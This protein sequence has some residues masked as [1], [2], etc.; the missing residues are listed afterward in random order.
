[1]KRARSFFFVCLG[2]LAL[3]TCGCAKKT[4]APPT[5][6]LPPEARPVDHIN[7]SYSGGSGGAM[8]VVATQD[9][10]VIL[11]PASSGAR[12]VFDTRVPL[13]LTLTCHAGG[14]CLG[15]GRTYPPQDS[16]PHPPDVAPDESRDIPDKIVI[17]GPAY[18]TYDYLRRH[19][20]ANSISI[21]LF[22]QDEMLGYWP[23]DSAQAWGWV[24]DWPAC[25]VAGSAE[26]GQLK[27]KYATPAKD[28]K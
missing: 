11:G 22:Y 18:D 13:R 14:R 12:I 8:W 23:Y 6:P 5:G 17:A 21:W 15:Y 2:I 19:W 16:V 28:T 20:E 25:G 4:T 9:T 24:P 7:V 3:A 27:A 10:E 26:V 1:M